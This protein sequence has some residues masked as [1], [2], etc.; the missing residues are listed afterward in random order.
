MQEIRML[1]ATKSER[2]ISETTNNPFIKTTFR[3]VTKVLDNGRSLYGSASGV[4]VFNEGKEPQAGDLFEGKIQQFETTPYEIEAGKPVTKI[5][6]VA[7]A[8]ENPLELANKQLEKYR[9]SVI[10][11]GKPTKVFEAP[12]P[13]PT[14]TETVPAT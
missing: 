6:V 11:D 1:E 12:K 5:S 7:F 13:T 2:F 9:A 8:D 14:V 10:L 4:R 3:A